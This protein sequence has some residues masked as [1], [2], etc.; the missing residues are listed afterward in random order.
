MPAIITDN[1]KIRNCTNFIN[2]VS[3][4]NYYTFIGLSNYDDYFSDWNSNTPDPVD[5]FGYLNEH[6]NTLLGVKKITTSDVIRVV[7]KIQW[8]TGLKY[9]MYRHDYSRYNLT[10]IT[11]STRLYDSRYYVLNKDYRVYICINNGAA[12]SNNNKGVISVNEPVHTSESPEIEND[13]YILKYLYTISP[14]DALKFD[15]TNYIS[16]PNNWTTSEDSEISRIRDSAVNGQIE[17][18][19]IESSEGYLIQSTSNIV[20]D[21]PIIGDGSGGLASVIFDEEGKP[22]SVTVTNGGSG[23]TFATLDLDSIVSPLSSKAV[24]NVIIPPPGGH[25]KN[26]YT[27]L[28]ANRVLVYSRIENTITNPD[29]I[30]G[31]QFARVGI[32]KDV[33]QYGSDTLFTDTTGSGVYG[34]IIDGTSASTEGEDSLITQNS[35]KAIGSLVSASSVSGLY[36]VVKYT[37]PKE[38]YVDT[39]SSGNI[40]KTSDRFLTAGVGLSTAA[41]YNYSN[42]NT[43]Q[44][45]IETNTYNIANVSGSQIGDVFLG[46]TFTSGLS[47]PDINTKSGEIVYIDN[48]ASV[49]RQSQQ[50]EDIKIIIEF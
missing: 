23:Y 20:N 28:G 13:G 29:F 5:N 39:Y 15:S 16:I 17:T 6:K 14:A 34:L 50:R 46:Q 43:D 48:R 31:N 12:P 35:T 26:V 3:N 42:F 18:I 45:I 47:N 7:P 40:T 11:N 9:D 10:P 19:L 27:E 24:F 4:G 2:D 21:V 30:E 37:K 32:I 44:I 22:I 38:F 1:L 25:G 49:S 8:T 41:S 33:T 36:T